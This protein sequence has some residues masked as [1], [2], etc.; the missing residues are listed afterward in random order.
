[1]AEC[2]QLTSLPLKGLMGTRLAEFC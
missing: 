2:N 1:M